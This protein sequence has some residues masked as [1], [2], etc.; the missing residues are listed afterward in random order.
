MVKRTR[1]RRTQPRQA[2]RTCQHIADFI[3]DYL[4]GELHPDTAAE[5]GEH[6]GIC[7]DCVAF[8]NTYKKTVQVTGSLPCED[9]PAEMEKRVRQ[10]LE[11][12]IKGGPRKR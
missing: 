8:L 2:D 7:P 6:L 1:A 4:T 11:E 5:F 12:K 10:F 9:I 3:L